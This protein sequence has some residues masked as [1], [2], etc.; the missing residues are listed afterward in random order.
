MHYILV[1]EAATSC[2]VHANCSWCKSN[3]TGRI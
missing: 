2:V 1:E 3:G